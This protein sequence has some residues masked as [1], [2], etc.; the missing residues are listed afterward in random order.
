MKIINKIIKKILKKLSRVVF[1]LIPNELDLFFKIRTKDAYTHYKENEILQCFNHFEKHLQNAVH[2][3]PQQLHWHGTNSLSIRKYAIEKS[4]LNDKEKN[5]FYLEFW[6]WKGTTANFFS[7]Y[8]NKL[9]AFD[10]FEGL[11]EDWI[12]TT[13][14]KNYLNLDKKIPKLNK[15]IEPIVGFIQDTLENFLKK[16]NPKINFAHMDMGTYESTKYALEKLKPYLIKD[17]I[18]LFDELYNFPGWRNGEYKALQ[19][20]FDES[21]YKFRAFATNRNGVVIQLN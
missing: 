7:E 8:V 18:I 21:E 2:L 16:H 3:E 15:N 17:S 1:H 9:Y 4:L 13:A 5:K 14:A 19:E 11:R 20:T 6:V 10:S 12:G